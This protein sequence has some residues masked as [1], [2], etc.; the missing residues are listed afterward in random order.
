MA[1]KTQTAE[2]LRA[3]RQQRL[4][5]TKVDPKTAAKPTL[6][7][8]TAKPEVKTSETVTAPVRELVARVADPGKIG[9]KAQVTLAGPY[10][11]GTDNPHWV[12]FADGEPLAKI[13]LA[14]QDSPDKIRKIFAT[15]D[16]AQS[17]IDILKKVPLVSILAS[18]KAR[19]YIASVKSTEAFAAV[20]AKYKADA[21]TEFQ[22]KAAKYRDDLLSMASLVV[23]GQ[24]KNFLTENPLKDSL[25]KHMKSAGVQDPVKVIEAAFIE[26]SAQYFEGT[27]K[28]AQKWLDYTP[29][30]LADIKQAITE[31]PTREVHAV[32]LTP[33]VREARA[34]PSSKANVAIAPTTSSDVRVGETSDKDVV[35]STFNFRG[36]MSARGMV[37]NG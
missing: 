29:E 30:A 15:A 23:E 16:Y 10:N 17:F 14:D 1:T 2:A 5:A 20:D 31:M 25:F 27:L 24:R 28:Q 13:A 37:Q 26:S 7:P 9:D 12:V 8:T 34:V 11:T 33:G 6:P 35:R 36:R 18:C 3:A 32:A 21:K 19:P 22:S 4:A